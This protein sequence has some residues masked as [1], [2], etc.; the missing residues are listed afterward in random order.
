MEKNLNKLT[1]S[2]LEKKAILIAQRLKNSGVE[3]EVIYARLD[4]QDIPQNIAK[5]AVRNVQQ[6]FKYIDTKEAKWD[7]NS[8]IM[9]IGIGVIAAFI[10]T[11]I[12]PG[13]VFIPLSLIGTGVIHALIAYKK[14]K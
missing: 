8:A 1:D 11:F 3:T 13:S 4:K 5:E 6:E 2:E 12:V 10:S 7:F 14:I 9:S